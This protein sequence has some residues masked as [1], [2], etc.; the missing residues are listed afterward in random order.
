MTVTVVQSGNK[1]KKE[2][3]LLKTGYDNI[4]RIKRKEKKNI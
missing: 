2:T 1:K 3:C 4:S